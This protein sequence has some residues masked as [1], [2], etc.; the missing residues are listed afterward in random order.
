VNSDISKTYATAY[1]TA[2]VEAA[3][4]ARERAKAGWAI[5]SAIAGTIV[6]AGFLRGIA[7]ASVATQL[8]TTAA[9]GAWLTAAW[10]FLLAVTQAS[11]PGASVTWTNARGFIERVTT[12]S[13]TESAAVASTTETARQI[14]LA[15]IVLTVCALLAGLFWTSDDPQGVSLPSERVQG[16]LPTGCVTD[17]MVSGTLSSRDNLILKIKIAEPECAK[18]VTLLLS[19]PEGGGVVLD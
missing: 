15:A 1:A 16:L 7:D 13:S 12:E 14:V 3:N 17:E 18:G 19:L 5:T 6:A 8:L 2:I 4:H 10:H 11:T 9:F